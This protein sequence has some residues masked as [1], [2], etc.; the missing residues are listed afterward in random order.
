VDFD[1]MSNCRPYRSENDSADPENWYLPCGIFALSVFS[2]NIIW[3]EPGVFSTDGIV[4]PSERE[5]LFKDLSSKYEGGIRWL[6]DLFVNGTT[7]DHFIVWMR[8]AFLGTVTKTFARCETCT[9]EKGEYTVLVEDTYPVEKFGGEK[10]VT[11]RQVPPLGRQ[12]PFLGVS[13]LTIGSICLGVG[14]ILTALDLAAPRRLG[15]EPSKFPIWRR[16]A[17]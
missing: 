9:I 15:E 17:T 10:R 7:D 16:S 12:N 1:G 4:Y 13:Y 14:A 8:T 6:D 3:P 11:L 5:D 2:D